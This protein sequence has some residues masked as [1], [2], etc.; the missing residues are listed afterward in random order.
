M[1]KDY[2]FMLSGLVPDT[3]RAFNNYLRTLLSRAIEEV[4]RTFSYVKRFKWHYYFYSG[5]AIYNF[6]VNFLFKFVCISSGLF[7]EIIS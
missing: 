7:G 2:R 5:N 1:T 4:C 3:V 6:E